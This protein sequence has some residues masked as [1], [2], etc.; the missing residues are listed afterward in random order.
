MGTSVDEQSA[1]E[2]GNGRQVRDH[3]LAQSRVVHRAKLLVHVA[4]PDAISRRGLV[5]DEL[6]LRRASRVLAGVDDERAAF[7]E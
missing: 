6:V 4:L 5:H 2:P 1:A 7:G 3:L